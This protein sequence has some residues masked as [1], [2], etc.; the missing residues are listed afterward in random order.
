MHDLVD[1]IASPSAMSLFLTIAV[2]CWQSRTAPP[3]TSYR[4]LPPCCFISPEVWGDPC[5]EPCWVHTISQTV[6]PLGY[7]RHY[8]RQYLASWQATRS[9]ILFPV[10][11]N[12]YSEIHNNGPPGVFNVF[13]YF[14]YMILYTDTD[15]S[16]GD[17]C[18]LLCWPGLDPGIL[19][20][21]WGFSSYL[22]HFLCRCCAILLHHRRGPDIFLQ[23]SFCW[24]LHAG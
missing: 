3:A 21:C 4:F 8:S 15:I 19:V 9:L 11:T 14:F 12:P 20:T 22:C 6:E 10:L 2:T 16:T 5:G 18:N 17:F 13:Y 1:I 24:S 7:S 23:G